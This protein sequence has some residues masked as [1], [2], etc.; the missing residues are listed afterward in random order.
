VVVQHNGL[1]GIF[2]FY[3]V[4]HFASWFSGFRQPNRLEV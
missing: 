2:Q 1:I 3:F 4:D